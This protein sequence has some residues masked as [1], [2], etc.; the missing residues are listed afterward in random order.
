MTPRQIDLPPDPADAAAM[1]QSLHDRLDEAERK[2]ARAERKAADDAAKLASIRGQARRA[3][4]FA[5]IVFDQRCYGLVFHVLDRDTPGARPMPVVVPTGA[6]EQNDPRQWPV[7]VEQTCRDTVAAQRAVTFEP[8]D[9]S[10]RERLAQAKAQREQVFELLA[11]E[12]DGAPLPLVVAKARE[13]DVHDRD[14][15]RAEVARFSEQ[16]ESTMLERDRLSALLAESDTAAKAAEEAAAEAV[17]GK[18]KPAPEPELTEEEL[19]GLADESARGA[20]EAQQ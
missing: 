16:L 18:H 13:A 19:E 17:T 12:D 14:E 2:L 6:F 7:V 15:A 11:V 10:E 9:P 1:V 5:R 4:A 8:L 20:A 3:D